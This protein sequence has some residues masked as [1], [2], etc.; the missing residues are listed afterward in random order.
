MRDVLTGAATVSLSA[1]GGGGTVSVPP[2][3]ASR[4]TRRGR[5]AA[6]VTF[7]CMQAYLIHEEAC[8]PLRR[9]PASTSPGNR[10]GT[11]GPG[12]AAVA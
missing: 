2:H 1:L 5:S 8:H 6:V 3:Q 9:F 4:R 12:V 7:I 10:D 11:S